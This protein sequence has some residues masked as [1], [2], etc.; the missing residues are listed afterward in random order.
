[1]HY[2]AAVVVMAAFNILN[3]FEMII[4][5]TTAIYKDGDSSNLAPSNLTYRFIDGP[6][7][8]EGRPGF[9]YVPQYTRYAINGDGDFMNIEKGT[10]LTW[11]ATKPD[12]EKGNPGGY[13]Y[14]RAVIRSCE[15]K[16][17]FRHRAMC[18]TFKP[19]TEDPA[20]MV[21]N[22]VDGVPGND[23]LSNLEWST[24]SKN[25]QHAYD[26]G[27]RV[28]AS[29]RIAVKDLKT[30]KVH[31][32]PT[33]QACAREFGLL[34]AAQVQWRASHPI[35][36]VYPDFLIVRYDADNLVWPEIDLS[37]QSVTRD[38]IP[39]E[40]MARNAFTGA[41]SMFNSAT[42]CAKVLG[43]SPTTVLNH[44][45]SLVDVPVGGFN[46]RFLSGTIDWPQHTAEQLSS[47]RTSNKPQGPAEE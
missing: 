42:Q 12:P 44:A 23:A 37:T 10:L 8:V 19:Y 22:H 40:I 17:L 38:G 41:V 45:H 20:T 6:I 24:Y 31:R 1:M 25:N 5:R 18:L 7:E 4:A 27:L 36:K 14:L 29:S 2:E 9:Y 39:S 47:F 46:F 28:K 33:M 13:R 32:F 16:I 26:L 35:D 11:T 34:T 30:G 15:N 21:V 3:D 43:V